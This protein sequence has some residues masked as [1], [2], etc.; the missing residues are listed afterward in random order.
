MSKTKQHRSLLGSAAVVLFSAVLFF[1]ILF[2][3]QYIVDSVKAYQYAPSADMAHIRSDL[4]LTSKGSFYFNASEPVIEPASEFN[5]SCRQTQETNNP[6]LGCYDA[7]RIYVFDVTNKKLAGIEQ[8]TAAHELLHAAYGRLGSSDKAALDTELQ[9]AYEQHKTPELIERMDYYKRTEPGEEM[10]ELHSILGTEISDVG[11]ILEDHYRQYFTDRSVITN[12]HNQ[13]ATIFSSV[14]NDIQ[15]LSTQINSQTAALNIRIDAYNASVQ[16][17]DSDAASFSKRNR[18]GEFTSA[19]EFNSE[20]NQLLQRQNA[21][22]DERNSIN[23]AINSID[24]LRT[25]YNQLVEEYNQLNSSINS[26]LTPV[27]SV[28][29]QGA[30]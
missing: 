4:R 23:V 19:D 17:L 13:Y 20:Q 10:N 29:A 3:R 15:R 25:Q 21:L 11:P 2:S 9:K 8:T 14:T 30:M 26:S 1:N 18:Q 28:N 16:Q 5:Q 6:I 7:E 12:F 24:G 22:A 27:N